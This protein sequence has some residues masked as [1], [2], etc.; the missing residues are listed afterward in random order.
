[1]EIRRSQTK[2]ERPN[3]KGRNKEGGEID[4]GGLEITEEDEKIN[5][6][7]MEDGEGDKED[8]IELIST[9]TQTV[10]DEREVDVKFMGERSKGE[11]KGG[12]VDIADQLEIEKEYWRNI[13]VTSRGILV[14][15]TKTRLS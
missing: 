14:W 6:G 10:E 2:G 4:R 9:V 3:E 7:R 13:G 12:G 8:D 1:M 11:K 5:E 15:G